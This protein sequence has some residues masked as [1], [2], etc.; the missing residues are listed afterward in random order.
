VVHAPLPELAAGIVAT[1][2]RHSDVVLG[3]VIGSNILNLTLILGLTTIVEPIDVNLHIRMVD[4]PV[5]VGASVA[6]LVLLA[7]YGA[8]LI[9][10]F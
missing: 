10:L 6:L 4:A 5:V 2:R 8:Y 3:N 9:Q 1:L 7:A